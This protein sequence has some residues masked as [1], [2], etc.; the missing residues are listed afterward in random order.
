MR[1][2]TAE[3]SSGR[4]EREITTMTKT[5]VADQRAG[6]DKEPREL[7]KTSRSTI[8]N[9][10]LVDPGLNKGY[11]GTQEVSQHQADISRRMVIGNWVI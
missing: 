6:P 7:F 2:G 9:Q 8:R 11:S 5:G 3:G 4:N 10:M 1:Q